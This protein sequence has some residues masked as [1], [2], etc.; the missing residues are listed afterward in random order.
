MIP[1]VLV[2]GPTGS[3]KSALALDIAEHFSGEI[4]NCDSLQLYRGFN[5]GTAKPTPQEQRRVPHHL[6][7]ILEPNEIFT[8]GDYARAARQVLYQVSARGHLPV[9]TGGTGFYARALLE[10]LFSGP[11]R[12][13]RLRQRLLRI[14]RRRSGFLHR[15]LA[16]FDRTAALRI[17]RND[18]NKLIRAIEVCVAA[19]RPMSELFQQGR[20]AL[21]GFHAIKIILDPPRPQLHQHLDTRCRRMLEHGLVHEIALLLLS[22]VSPQWKP[23]EAIGYKEVLRFLLGDLSLPDALDL[24]QR[25]T[26]RYAKRQ[27]TWFRR[28]IDALWVTGFGTDLETRRSVITRLVNYTQAQQ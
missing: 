6:F 20:D 13:D 27:L 1:L 28:E 2:L 10:G 18:S 9:V 5:I 22:G 16:R 12:D 4:V 24:M 7:N 15:A 8:A 19:R 17:H 21:T 11:P 26:R 14:E 25:D 23:F 3:G